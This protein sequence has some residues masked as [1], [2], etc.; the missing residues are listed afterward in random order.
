MPD[1][2]P[3]SVLLTSTKGFDVEK[4]KKIVKI[5]EERGAR[6]GR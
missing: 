6:V 5:K 2:G 4:F 1:R 3:V